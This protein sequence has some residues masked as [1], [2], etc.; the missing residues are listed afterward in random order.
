MFFEWIE[1][2]ESR[3]GQNT[4]VRSHMHVIWFKRAC[5][6]AQLYKYIYRMSALWLF[7]TAFDVVI[8][9]ITIIN[10]ISIIVLLTLSIAI[11]REHSAKNSSH[12]SSQFYILQILTYQ[13]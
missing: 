2:S 6:S 3:T 12:K 13:Y 9:T 5:Y 11:E 8:V 1:Y 10:L 7:L 4:D